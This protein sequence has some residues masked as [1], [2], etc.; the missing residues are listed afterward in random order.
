MT[1]PG[2]LRF[3]AGILAVLLCVSGLRPLR[4]DLIASAPVAGATVDSALAADSAPGDLNERLRALGLDDDECAARLAQLS[5][6]EA[7]QLAA[8]P[9]QVQ[10]AGDVSFGVMLVAAAVVV[11]VVLWLI[12]TEKIKL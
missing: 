7:A 12:G 1:T 10:V 6:E 11:F 5:P 8:H 3:A 4:A 2:S 9:E